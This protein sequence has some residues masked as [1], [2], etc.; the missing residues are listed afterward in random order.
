[1][2]LSIFLTY[3]CNSRCSMCHVWQHPT[4]PAE[5]IPLPMLAQLPARFRSITL[6][7]GEPTL[8]TDLE[9]V[10]DLLRPKTRQLVIVTNA[11][12]PG[13]LETIAQKH[14]DIHILVSLDG[15][16]PKNDSI[17]GEKNGFERKTETLRRLAAAGARQI[18]FAVTLQDDNADQILALYELS[19]AHRAGWIPAALH[20]GFQFLKIDNEPLNRIRIA[21]AIPP[22]AIMLLKSRRPADWRLAYLHL[23]LMRKI[24]GQPRPYPCCAGRNAAIIDPWGRV[25]ACP[26]RPDLEIGDLSAQTWKEILRSPRAAEARTR[27]ACCTHNCWMLRPAHAATHLPS[28]PWIPRL[29]PLTWALANKLRVACGIPPDFDRHVNFHDVAQSPLVPRRESWLGKPFRPSFLCKTEQPYGSFNH[30]MNK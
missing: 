17:R 24:L 13:K 14:P 18:A 26:L 9:R 8:R 11:L 20:N 5:E 29:Q 19:R 27:V 15:I 7:G 10:V 6:T 4:L 2:D 12:Q 3:R 30:V 16:G 28:L 21:R 22:L 23:G 25:Y 1:M